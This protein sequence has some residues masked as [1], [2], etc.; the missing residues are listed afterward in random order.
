M[1][2]E[3]QV[4]ELGLAADLQLRVSVWFAEEG[5]TVY[6]GDRL[7][8]LLIPGATFDVAC[9]ADGVLTRILV[10]PND[11]VKAGQVVGVVDTRAE[12]SSAELEP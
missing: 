9:P 1:P 8:E 2:A 7:V 5:D 4:P 10:A 3:V 12:T 6:E 11:E